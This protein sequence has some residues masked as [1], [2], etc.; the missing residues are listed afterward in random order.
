MFFT[1]YIYSSVHVRP[2]WNVQTVIDRKIKIQEL[3]SSGQ[4]TV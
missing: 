3:V 1:W 2:W 4:F